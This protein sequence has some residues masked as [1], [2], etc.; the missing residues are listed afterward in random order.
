[1]NGDIEP[2]NR[3]VDGFAPVE[4]TSVMR[5]LVVA[6]RC[7]QQP[8]IDVRVTPMLCH[9]GLSGIVGSTRNKPGSAA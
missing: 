6:L 1:M 2:L 4:A 9:A 3:I 7:R 8:H 5:E